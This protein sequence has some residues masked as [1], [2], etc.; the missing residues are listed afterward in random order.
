MP[1]H[2]RTIEYLVP[3]VRT[4]GTN[5]E[6]IP[7]HVGRGARSSGRGWNRISSR[8]VA[9]AAAPSTSEGPRCSAFLQLDRPLYRYQR[10]LWLRPVEMGWL[11]SELRRQRRHD[12]RSDWL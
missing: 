12:R 8:L 11:A 7:V 10:R 5:N 2:G 9:S 3:C 6:S 4:G 1:K